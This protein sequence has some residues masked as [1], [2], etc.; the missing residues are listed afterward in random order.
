MAKA[1]P[2][3][4]VEMPIIKQDVDYAAECVTDFLYD[5][6]ESE[7]FE[8]LGFSGKAFREEIMT[9]APFL[10]VVKE[11]V[12]KHGYEALECP[13]DYIDYDDVYATKEWKSLFSV[14]Q[15]LQQV[16]VDIERESSVETACADAIMTLKRAGFQIVKA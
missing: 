5:E 12:S 7:V 8:M 9:F 15:Q 13:Y 3:M 4:I 6:F 2:F 16:L 14:C 1:K 11:A 10:E